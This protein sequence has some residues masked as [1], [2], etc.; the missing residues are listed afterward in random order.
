MNLPGRQA[1]NWGFRFTWDQV[2][3]TI[4][5]RLAELVDLYDR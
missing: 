2:T 4:A 3:P 1:G 5:S